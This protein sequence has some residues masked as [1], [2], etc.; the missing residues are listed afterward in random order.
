MKG[1]V[2]EKYR[3]VFRAPPLNFRKNI[4]ESTGSGNEFL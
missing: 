1:K 2:E 4:Y 3:L